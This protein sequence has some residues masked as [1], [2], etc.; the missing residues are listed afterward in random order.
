MRG[1]ACLLALWM[2][3]GCYRTLIHDKGV[4][5]NAPWVGVDTRAVAALYEQPD[6]VRGTSVELV[7]RKGRS[8]MS[9]TD[10][11]IEWGDYAHRTG[12]TTP[13]GVRHLV[14][15]FPTIWILDL[16]AAP[17]YEWVY[18]EHGTRWNMSDDLL[19]IRPGASEPPE[20][21]T[22]VVGPHGR[23]SRIQAEWGFLI[24]YPDS[25]RV[26]TSDH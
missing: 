9:D 2:C 12:F 13:S 17:T 15:L 21:V 26:M 18:A 25:G 24:V 14:G 1:V 7:Y 10:L 23:E 16:Q 22:F 8:K 4:E 5:P 3:A 19:V 11:Q 6:L 20:K